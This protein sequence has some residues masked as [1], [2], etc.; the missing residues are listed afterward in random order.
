MEKRQ[1]AD[2]DAQA[3]DRLR[4]KTTLGQE[5][6]AA[7]RIDHPGMR[8]HQLNRPHRTHLDTWL[9]PPDRPS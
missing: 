4:P 7:Q 3:K 9:L 6:S 8:R 2:R 1:Q 5:E